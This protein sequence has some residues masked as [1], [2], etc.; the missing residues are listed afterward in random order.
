MFHHLLH[1]LLN[2]TLARAVPEAE[3]AAERR[4]P[5]RR[6][7]CILPRAIGHFG[8]RRWMPSTVL[9][10]PL[11]VCTRKI[12]IWMWYFLASVVGSEA[13]VGMTSQFHL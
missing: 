6:H 5:C 7:S 4:G 2:G 3:N 11:H 13:T 10:K 1:Q 8:L 9:M 12:L